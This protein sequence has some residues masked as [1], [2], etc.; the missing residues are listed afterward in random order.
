[1]PE[2][3]K[4]LNEDSDGE[5]LPLSPGFGE[6]PDDAVLVPIKGPVAPATPS[7]RMLRQVAKD[8]FQVLKNSQRERLPVLLGDKNVAHSFPNFFNEFRETGRSGEIQDGIGFER[9]P[10]SSGDERQSEPRGES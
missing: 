3:L 1:M 5:R 6:R 8:F 4:S 10:V 2:Q 9:V 7:Q